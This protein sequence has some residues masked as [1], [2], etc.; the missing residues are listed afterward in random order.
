MKKKILNVVIFLCV[1]AAILIT[2]AVHREPMYQGKPAALWVLE[3]RTDRDKALN[4]LQHMGKGALPAL[5]EMLQSN[6][7]TEKCRAAWAMGR[8]GPDAA[9]EAVP[10]LLLLLDDG[11][12]VLQSEAMHS[13]SR[14]GITN[15]DIV[16]KLQAQL[17]GSNDAFAAELL[18]SI[19]RAR[20]AKNLPPI[21]GDEF[22]YDMAFLKA[23][24]LSVRFNGA[25]KLAVLAQKDERAKAALKSLLNDEDIAVRAETA[26]IMANINPT[27]MPNY[28]MVSED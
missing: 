1:P 5:R 7:P 14:I 10:D 9:R 2:A 24:T 20:K 28:K 21:S 15:Q 3:I 26:R 22:D 11:N 13:L 8:L 18:I 27:A 12:V 23:P 25:L 4:A 16:P 19:E 17:T 6:S